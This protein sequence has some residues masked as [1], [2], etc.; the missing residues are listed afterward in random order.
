MITKSK[1]C[2]LLWL[3]LTLSA[4]GGGGGGGSATFASFSALSVLQDGSGVARGR[5]QDGERALIYGPEISEIVSG[6]NNPNGDDTSIADI[7][8]G[9]FPVLQSTSS[10]KLLGGTVSSGSYIF[11]IKAIENTSTTNAGLVFL[12][13]PGYTDM[14]MAVGAQYSNPP[15]SGVYTYNGTQTSNS[16]SIVAPGSI[17]IFTLSVD[18]SARNFSY[19]GSSGSL[20]LNASGVLDNANGFFASSNADVRVG[21]TSYTG[22]IHGQLHGSSATSTSGV[23]HT[24]DYRPDYSGGFVGSR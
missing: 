5:A 14:I 17:G 16:R 22:V 11:N 19:S 8:S 6:A 9:D 3:P 4:C 2:V 15:A 20:S 7:D 18:F 12:E 13:V 21:A 24:T 23:F 1:I 10:Y